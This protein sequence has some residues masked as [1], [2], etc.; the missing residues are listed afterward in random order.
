MPAPTFQNMGFESAGDA[1]GLAAFWT[2]AWLASA[3]EIAGYGSPE[4][5]AEDFERGW[6]DNDRFLSVLEPGK[7]LPRF[8]DRV[9][10][11]LEDFEEGWSLNEAFIRELASVAPADYDPGPDPKLVE[12]FDQLW[13]DNEAF[14]ASFE[15]SDLVATPTEAF[16][17]NWL[18]NQSFLFAFGAG[19]TSLGPTETFEADWTAMTTV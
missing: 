7:A 19:D 10:E 14:L 9:A 3:A 5:P 13:A 11:P 15:P 8:F 18:G 17:S 2:L 12:D 16:E 4:R 1:P 6:A